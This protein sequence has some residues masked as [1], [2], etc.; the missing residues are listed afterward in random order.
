[1][2]KITLDDIKKNKTNNILIP[3]YTVILAVVYSWWMVALQD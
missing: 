1:M 3:F 2:T